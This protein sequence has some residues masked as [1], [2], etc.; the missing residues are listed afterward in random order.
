MT[1]ELRLE[2]VFNLRDLGGLSTEDGRRV[3]RGRLFRSDDPLMATSADREALRELNLRTVLDLRHDDEVERR[4]SAVWTEL[5]V[6]VVRCS[7]MSELPGN[8]AWVRFTDPE[9]VADIY[10]DLLI[11][12]DLG[13]LWWQTLAAAAQAPVLIHCASGRD[14][15]GV[16]AAMLLSALGVRR[17]QVIEDYAISAPGMVR[18]LA[19]LDEHVPERS[20]RDEGQR[21]TFVRTPADCMA[22]FLDAVDKR[23]GSVE[24]YLTEV[25]VQEQVTR[26]RAALL[27]VSS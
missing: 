23:W 17:D 19:H 20:P 21:Y 9:Y 25:G 6:Q 2:R 4:G 11:D 18:L 1:R 12:V 10:L 27:E 24:G 15:T 16:V 5:G 14:R 26:M 3:R 8:S 22:A 13:R 7:L